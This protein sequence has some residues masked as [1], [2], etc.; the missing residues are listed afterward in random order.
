MGEEIALRRMLHRKLFRFVTIIV[1]GS[2]PF[3]VAAQRI[4]SVQV[5]PRLSQGNYNSASANAEAWRLYRAKGTHRTLSGSQM[6][7]VEGV[8][9]QYQP[10]THVYGP[11]GEL[12]HV[13]MAFTGGRPV[14][15]GV[16]A[17]L[18]RVINFTARKEYRISSWSEHMKVRAL[19]LKMLMELD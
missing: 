6:T 8:L 17:D 4:D 1:F 10:S 14:A 19:L 3:M 15:L 16:T 7:E 5:F 9:E 12:T 11:L 18:G 13:A 2:M